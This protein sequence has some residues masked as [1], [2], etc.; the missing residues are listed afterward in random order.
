MIEAAFAPQVDIYRIALI[1]SASNGG[2]D[3]LLSPPEN[4]QQITSIVKAVGVQETVYLRRTSLLTTA[5]SG[6]L[7]IPNQLTSGQR[8]SAFAR[9]LHVRA[10]VRSGYQ[11]ASQHALPCAFPL[12][13]VSPKPLFTLA[14]ASLTLRMGSQTDTS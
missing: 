3:R 7:A 1:S 14:D 12:G 13:P 9:P 8:R 2:M 5:I 10:R 11:F 4:A 6:P